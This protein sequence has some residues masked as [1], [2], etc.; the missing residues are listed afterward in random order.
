MPQSLGRLLLETPF[1][2]G[3]SCSQVGSLV[4]GIRV[5]QTDFLLKKQMKVNRG[6][7]VSEVH[8]FVLDCWYK[9]AVPFGL[10]PSNILP[11]SLL[12]GI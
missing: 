8:H 7:S 4:S 1:Q 10:P 6:H 2:L 11:S 3:F 5:V 9:S 12:P